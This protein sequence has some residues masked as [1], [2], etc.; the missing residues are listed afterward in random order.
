MSLRVLTQGGGSAG[1]KSASIFITGLDKG[2]TVTAT[3]DGKTLNGVWNSEEN[4]FEITGITDY[5]MWTV[6]ATDGDST[7]TQDVL[8]DVALEYQIVMVYEAN[9]LMLYDFGDQCEEIT[10]GWDG[11]RTRQPGTS[12]RYGQL[13]ESTM[14]LSYTNSSGSIWSSCDLVTEKMID[15]SQYV[16]AI[17][18]FSFTGNNPYPNF[19]NGYALYAKTSTTDADDSRWAFFI[20]APQEV[21]GSA[22]K[23]TSFDGVRTTALDFDGSYLVIASLCYFW[24]QPTTASLSVSSLALYK[25]DD[26]KTLCSKAGISAPANLTALIS[27][28]SSIAAIL[29]NE[30]AVKFM[31]RKCT[32]DFMA[33]FVTSSACMSALASSPYKETVYANYHWSKFL[34]MVQ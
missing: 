23:I 34:A 5:G 25:A 27:N 19:Y 7:V 30:S 11:T 13:S 14:E 24:S 9:Y 17:S 8:V 10:G 1:G 3:K 28:A 12:T 29:N 20:N 15:L 26:W 16:G 4:R 31:V 6:T 2:S 21:G 33:A 18:K 22:E 32:G